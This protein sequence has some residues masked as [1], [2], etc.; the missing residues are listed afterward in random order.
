MDIDEDHHSQLEE[1]AASVSDGL[2]AGGLPAQPS[3]P[4]DVIMEQVDT[5]SSFIQFGT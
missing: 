4:A 1:V 3:E 2:P 5:Q